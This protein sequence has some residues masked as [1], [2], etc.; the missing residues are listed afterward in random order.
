MYAAPARTR[1][2]PLVM[3]L[4]ALVPSVA[5]AARVAD[6]VWLS[7]GVLLVMA[8]TSIA[9]ALL[10]GA[11]AQGARGAESREAGEPQAGAPAAAGPTAEDPT[12]RWLRALV[13]SSLLTAAFEAGLLA[14]APAASASLGIY[15][16]LIA[17]NFLVVGTGGAGPFGPSPLR[18]ALFSLRTGAWFA[19]GLVAIALARE[20][21]AAGTITLF[22]AGGFGGTITVSPLLDQP[23]RALGLAGGGL[24]CLGYLIA[25]VRAVLTRKGAA[26]P[27]EEAMK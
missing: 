11:S 3:L 10:D 18:A 8:G 12:A 4:L 16:P 5:V 14:A 19:G 25:A 21:L 20:V 23:V 1:E 22:P 27:P 6:A 17:V 26:A 2:A 13:V 15:A 7:I 24:L 9:R